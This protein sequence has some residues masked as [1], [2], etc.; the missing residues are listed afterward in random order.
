[1]DG[2]VGFKCD[3]ERSSSE[4]GKSG[5]GLAR[6]GFLQDADPVVLSA[7][8]PLARWL[9]VGPSTL[10]LDFG[11]ATDDVFFVVEGAVRVL[12]RTPLGQ[13]VILGDLGSGDVFGEMAAIDGVP[14]SANVTTLHAARL[15]RLPAA[16]FLDVALR[17]P[18]V[19][20]RLM[21]V[22]TARLRLQD[23]RLFEQV[24]LPVRHR[25]ASELLRL[26]RPREGHGA[27]G[28]V[29]S[30]PPPQHVLAA[31]IGARRETVS[32]SMAE[33]VRE[34]L[35]EASS[36]AIVIPQPDALRAAI[37]V[38]LRGSVTAGTPR[39]KRPRQ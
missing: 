7:A 23:E 19:S 22:M 10:V 17:S 12:V 15:C 32:L 13:E 8:A 39:S 29:V 3:W 20:L 25:L 4:T 5:N 9:T 26:S 38:L 31:R 2:G 35:I 14:R 6:L 18:A 28:R 34:G 37:G 33:L 16:A 36:R 24:V 1:M 30:P 21:Q 27:A 11:D